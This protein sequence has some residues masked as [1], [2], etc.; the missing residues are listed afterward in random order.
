[1]KYIIIA[2]IIATIASLIMIYSG[3]IEDKKKFLRV[4]NTHVFLQMI[5]N[6]LLNGISGVINNVLTIIRNV[7]SVN[8]KLNIF[9]KIIITM[10][11]IVLTVI[12]NNLGFI[13]LFPL[14]ASI[15]YIWYMNTPDIIK[16]KILNIVT[17]I[18]WLFYDFTIMS[19]SSVVFEILTIIS[20]S[21][22]IYK[23]SKM[24]KH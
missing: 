6:S 15:L 16:L 19:Y 23:I 11:S 9:A 12:F 14:M 21:I 1:M 24:R 5:S 13:G 22:S 10:I 20:N 2:N 4:Q 7:L 17:L 3:V 18:L 8:N